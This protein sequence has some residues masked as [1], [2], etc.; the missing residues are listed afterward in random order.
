MFER[1][2]SRRLFAGVVTTFSG[3]LLTITGG[4]KHD[5]IVVNENAGNV[6]VEVNYQPAADYT[7]VTGIVVKGGGAGDDIYHTGN[8]LH[9]KIYGNSGNDQLSVAD[10]GTASSYV[11]GGAGDDTIT[12][13]HGN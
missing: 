6:H 2:E 11:D 3:G 8:T 13:I 5:I 12:L 4:S 7:G 10:Y 9:P 1:L